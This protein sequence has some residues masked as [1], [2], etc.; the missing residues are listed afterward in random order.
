MDPAA[1]VI[2]SGEISP[3]FHSEEQSAN[4]L[5]LPSELMKL[6]YDKLSVKEL[7]KVQQVSKA[8]EKNVKHCEEFNLY[9]TIVQNLLK[10]ETWSSLYSKYEGALYGPYDPFVPSHEKT[11]KADEIFQFQV[12]PKKMEDG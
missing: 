7:C 4:N 11:H 6:I 12:V 2:G 1:K 9:K 10:G 3:F 5:R 8:F